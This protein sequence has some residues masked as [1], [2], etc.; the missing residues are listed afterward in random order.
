MNPN[1]ETAGTR[2][3]I[4]KITDVFQIPED[5][6]EAFLVD[7]KNYYQIGLDMSKLIDEVAKVGGIDTK[8]LPQKMTWIDDDRHDVKIYLKSNADQVRANANQSTRQSH[9]Q[10]SNRSKE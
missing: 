5:K 2:Y 10:R 3:D 9:D 4:E 8:T 1:S 6:F 7:F